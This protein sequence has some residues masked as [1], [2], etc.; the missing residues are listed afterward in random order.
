MTYCPRYTHWVCMP[1]FWPEHA[2]ILAPRAGR[3]VCAPRQDRSVQKPSE[4]I[5]DNCGFSACKTLAYLM[6]Q[7]G[8]SWGLMFGSNVTAA[9][10]LWG[11]ILEYED[12][13]RAEYMQIDHLWL[14]GPVSPEKEQQAAALSMR[15]GV[16][17]DISPSVVA[18]SVRQVEAR[19][20]GWSENGCQVEFGRRLI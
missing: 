14:D 12:G 8:G 4:Y 3:H 18:T 7:I 19:K 2:I 20:Y 11:Q 5:A 9:V 17:C 16:G 1:I 10:K 13:Y 15:Y 6:D